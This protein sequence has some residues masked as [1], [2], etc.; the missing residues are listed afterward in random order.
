MTRLVDIQSITDGGSNVVTIGTA[1]ALN[2]ATLAEE[3]TLASTAN[4]DGA[5][6]IGVEDAATN[7]AATDVEG[8]L[9]EMQTSI[10]AVDAISDLRYSTA[11]VTFNGGATQTLGTIP[12]N[13]V[14]TEVRVITTTVFD[15]TSPTITIGNDIDGNAVLADTDDF[16]IDGSLNQVQQKLEWFPNGDGAAVYS[17]G[18]TSGGSTAGEAEV[19]FFYTYP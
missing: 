18:L 8:V 3:P 1:L 13:A 9:A 4:G 10:D 14:V 15:G 11:T 17:V 6:L 7:W 19:I 5:S 16:A 2:G 12:L